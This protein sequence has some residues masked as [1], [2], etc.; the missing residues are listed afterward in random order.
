MNILIEIRKRAE[1]AIV[2][3]IILLGVYWWTHVPTPPTPGY[4]VAPLAPQL[5]HTPLVP[6]N[7]PRV[8]AYAPAVKKRLGLPPEV[9]ANQHA[10]VISASKLPA[11]DH[12]VTVTTLLDDQTGMETTLVRQEPLPWLAAEERGYLS[13]GGGFKSGE[14]RVARLAIGEDLIQVK[15]LHFGIDGTMDSDGQAYGGVHVRW[16]W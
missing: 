8:M 10:H 15:A 14:G 9:Q 16:E 5:A 12:P 7:P 4:H 11:D 2:A 3:A 13:V 1:G 6:I